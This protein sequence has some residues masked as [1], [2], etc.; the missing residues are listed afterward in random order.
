MTQPFQFP[1]GQ[2]AYN[3]DD[4]IA[5]CQQ[6]PDDGTNYLVREDLEKWLAYIGKNDIAQCAMSARQAALTD[7]Q[8]L[9]EFLHKCH[10]LSSPETA[11]VISAEEKKSIAETTV[12]VPQTSITE[13]QLEQPVTKIRPE[14]ETK[15]TN[16][17]VNVVTQATIQTKQTDKSAKSQVEKPSFF[18]LI[19]S[20]VINILYRDKN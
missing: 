10:S 14:P 6:F 5:L 20:F 9:E 18:K 17:D 4:L 1:N 8:K 13:S 7:R 3:A 12:K 19:A 16:E 11:S 2:L 15:N